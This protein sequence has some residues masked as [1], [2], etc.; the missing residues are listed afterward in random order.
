[1]VSRDLFHEAQNKERFFARL[2]RAQNDSIEAFFRKRFRRLR[3]AGSTSK[4]KLRTG[5]RRRPNCALMPVEW[6]SRMSARSARLFR[7]IS[8]F[9]IAL[10]LATPPAIAQTENKPGPAGLE[11]TVRDTQHHSLAGATV[12][13]QSTAGGQPLVAQTDSKGRY[14]FNAIRSGTYDLRATMPGYRETNKPG[15]ILSENRNAAV[16]LVLE[17]DAAGQTEKSAEQLS[18]EYSDQP[19]FTVA[20]VTD[21]TNLGGHGS[22]VLVRTKEELAKE[23]ASL[24]RSAPESTKAGASGPAD[25][26]KNIRA[27]LAREDRANLHES[28]ADIEE[29]EGRP[30]EAVREYQKAA[31]MEPSEAYLFSWGAE[32]LLHRAPEPAA[33]VFAKGRRLFPQSAQMLEGLGVAAYARGSNEEAVELLLSACDLNPSDPNSYSLLAKIQDS[34]KLAIPG[35]AERLERFV[36][37]QPENA[38]AL[39]YYAVALSK[40]NKAA[41]NSEQVERLLQKAIRLD[42]H[43][44]GAYLQLGILYSGAEGFAEGD[45]CVIKRRSK[46]RRSLRKLIFD[47]RKPTGKAGKN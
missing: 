7:L 34:E 45:R 35:W 47:W 44:G 9:V 41:E 29:R 38:A 40:E 8:S 42:S 31:E 27:L 33:E 32:L 46:T 11:G 19:Q 2:R 5:P 1:M 30:L 3:A 36:S 37:L 10:V 12:S 17:K 16:D 6:C 18:L 43:L 39:Y 13:L 21:P 24:N 23:T 25:A 28:L 4:I 20:G 14:R 22:D 15:Q 26:E